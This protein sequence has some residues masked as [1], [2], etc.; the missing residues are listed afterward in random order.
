M[1]KSVNLTRK[2]VYEEGFV[3]FSWTTAF[4]GPFEP[5]RRGDL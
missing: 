4:L 1:A 2:Y 5:L 3:G